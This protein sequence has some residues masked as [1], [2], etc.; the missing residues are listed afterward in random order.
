MEEKEDRI[1]DLPD[2]IIHHILS[3]LPSTKESIQTGILSKRWRNQWTRVPVLIFDFA[4]MYSV[5][6]SVMSRFID[7]TLIRHNC[8]KIKKFYLQYYNKSKDDLEYT[9][10]IYF[11]TTKDVE[12]LDL[13]SLSLGLYILPEFLF[14]TASLVKLT[15]YNCTF[16][17]SGK[18]N[19][20]CLTELYMDEC[21]LTDQVMEHVLSGSPLLK[22]LEV[23]SCS[24]FDKFVIASKSMK[25]L[26][27]L[28]VSIRNVIEISC[29]NLEELSIKATTI[30]DTKVFAQGIENV[31]SVSSV[32]ES[33]ELIDCEELEKLAIASKS[34]K[35][36][37]I[38]KL[39]LRFVYIEISCPK[40]EKLELFGLLNFETAKLLNLPSTLCAAI[41]FYHFEMPLY[42][43]SSTIEIRKC[44][45][46]DI[47]HQF[48]H[49]NDLRIGSWI[50]K[51]LSTIEP[52]S[53]FF[54]VLNVKRLT[55]NSLYLNNSGI[56]LVLRG[57]HVLEKLVIEMPLIDKD[58]YGLPELNDF[59]ENYWNSKVTV[60]NCLTSHLKAI[61]I[62]G[63]P[64]RDGEC[65][66][67]LNFVQFLLSNAEVLEKIVVVLKDDKTAFSLDVSQNLLSMPR[68]SQYAVVELP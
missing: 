63:F 46:R 52:G 14:N 29:P 56:A 11:A 19:W 20:G 1:S 66:L 27:L 9:E 50:I 51:I 21:K 10:K 16:M 8:S 68:R 5:E 57:S 32:L 65:K 38:G 59:G 23:S 67:V 36:L 41:D 6:S 2:H 37:V 62:I 25:R 12:E 40:L 64:E 24:Q 61:E 35:R 18:V 26:V 49:V 53:L 13:I 7:C 42:D 48:K 55:L 4:G 3:F 47:L 31:L 34:L 43:D 45:I 44:L 54:P 17:P 28:D 30:S 33:F 15:T 39:T 58:A 22:S 60:F